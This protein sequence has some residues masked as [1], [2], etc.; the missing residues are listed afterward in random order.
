M[1][2]TIIK[3][4]SCLSL[5][6]L[7]F[8][9][10]SVSSALQSV[11]INKPCVV[12][13]PGEYPGKSGKR[14]YFADKIPNLDASKY[15]TE[16]NGKELGEYY[17]NKEYCKHIA[18][19]IREKDSRIVV[20][21]FDSKNSSTDLNSAGRISNAYNAD[22]YL[23]IHHNCCTMNSKTPCTATGFICMTAKGNYADK[24]VKVAKHISKNIDEAGKDT[25]LYHF[26][27]K[28]DGIWTGNTYVGELNE[29]TH[30]SPAVLIEMAFFDNVHDLKISTDEK[31]VD[32]ISERVAE[33]IV[34]EFH[35]GTFDND[36][37]NETKQNTVKNEK[38]K[39][40]EENN[41]SSI[42]VDDDKDKNIKSSS[43][44]KVQKMK[45]IANKS[46]IDLLK[47]RVLGS[48]RT[49]AGHNKINEILK[50]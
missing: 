28:K 16:N 22:L 24:S 13:H 39:R 43:D 2:K 18:Q 8:S 42:K 49:N 37:N 17:L 35:K 32:E 47:S 34:N 15:K 27:G 23:A 33:A 5:I 12:I 46:K 41:N 21:E 10:V 38:E 44:D 25:D 30:N 4:V 50:R 14:S 26:V 3:K 20:I 1:K 40:L 6:F 48:H 11:D 36:Q 45:E 9:F 19:Y 29:A 7:L 31:K